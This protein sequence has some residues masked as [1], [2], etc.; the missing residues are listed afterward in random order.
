LRGFLPPEKIFELVSKDH[1]QERRTV[2]LDPILCK[3]ARDRGAD[4][5]RRNYFDHVNPGGQGPNFLVRRAG[6]V[7]P[8][9]YDNS[10]SGNNIE[11]IAMHTG[12]P[13]A[14]FALWMGSGPHR[15]HLL[16]NEAFYQ[17]QTSVGVGV[18]R[19][20][21]PP[22]YRYYVFLS[23]PANQSTRPPSVILKDPKGKIIARTRPA[24]AA[25]PAQFR[26]DRIPM[27]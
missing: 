14:A 2:A 15:T 25:L 12:D 19:S 3:V 26:A 18:L 13:K 17:E 22:H 9:F 4:M 11:S 16:G 20:P 7:L 8:S 10:R 21:N 27:P 24:V 23:A 6:F 1:G 5:A